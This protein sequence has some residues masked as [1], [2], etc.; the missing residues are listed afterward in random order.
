MA[1]N[2]S[3]NDQERHTEEHAWNAPDITPKPQ[4]KQDNNRTQIEGTA[5]QARLQNITYGNLQNPDTDKYQKE[6]AVAIRLCQ[7]N[8]RRKDRRD[9]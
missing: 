6:Q 3:E 7:G 9:Y 1:Q 5:H 4:V 2:N 8:H